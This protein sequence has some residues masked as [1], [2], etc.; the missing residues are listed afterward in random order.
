MRAAIGIVGLITWLLLGAVGIA[1]ITGA[2]EIPAPLAVILVVTDIAA[3]VALGSYLLPLSV[4][5]DR[6]RP[7]SARVAA[8]ESSRRL[9]ATIRTGGR[10]GAMRFTW[11]LLAVT[12]YE[13]GV[14]F[15]PSFLNAF[16]IF[17]NEIVKITTTGKVERVVEIQH[18]STEVESP[19]ALSAALGGDTIMKLLGN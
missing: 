12:V 11:P 18:T 1:A 5:G 2:I 15:K 13:T 7:D 3:F 14:V 10:V 8:V 9:A 6:L 17:R 4:Y 16:A 19:V